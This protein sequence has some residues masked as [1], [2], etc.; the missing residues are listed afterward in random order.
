MTLDAGPDQ[1]LETGLLDQGAAGSL[2]ATS[3]KGL[4]LNPLPN[5]REPF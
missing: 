5:R 1:Q 3:V 2:L 4:A